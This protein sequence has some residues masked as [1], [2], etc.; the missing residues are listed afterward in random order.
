[1]KLLCVDARD[2]YFLVEGGIYEGVQSEN[3]PRYWGVQISRHGLVN[4]SKTRFIAIE[5]V[6]SIEELL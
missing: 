1:M 2:S 3:S 4:Y 5:T 6:A